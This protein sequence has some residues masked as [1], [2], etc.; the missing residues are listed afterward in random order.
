MKTI[1]RIEEQDGTELN[2][3][4][5]VVNDSGDVVIEKALTKAE[6]GRLQLNLGEHTAGTWN[7]ESYDWEGK[8]VAGKGFFYEVR[9]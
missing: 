1:I 7:G 6:Y 2:A 8:K 5:E 9:I 3:L 4:L